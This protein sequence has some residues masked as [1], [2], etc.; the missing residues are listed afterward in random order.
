MSSLPPPKKDFVNTS[1][2][3]LE[4]RNWTSPVVH[5]FTLKLEFLWNILSVLVVEIKDFNAL[6]SNKPLFDQPIKNKQK[7]YE[8]PVDL[9]KMMIVQQEMY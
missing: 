2:R 1:K 8:K 7:V 9:S 5:Y 3:L 6:I 4:N